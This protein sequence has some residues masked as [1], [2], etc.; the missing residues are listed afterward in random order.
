MLVATGLLTARADIQE[1]ILAHSQGE[2]AQRRNQRR[3]L[4]PAD[5]SPQEVQVHQGDSI[6][7]VLTAHGRPGRTI[8]F[9]IRSQPEHGTIEGPPRQL[10]RNTVSVTYVH[11]AADGPGNDRFTYAVQA[12]GT[13][14]SAPV[15]VTITVLDEP[16]NLV[17]TPAELDFGVVKTGENTRATLTLENRGG[18]TAIGRIEPPPPWAVD[19]SAEYHLGHG[20]TQSFQVVFQPPYGQSYVESAHV[21]AENGQDVRLIGSGIGPVDPSADGSIRRALPSDGIVRA[22]GQSP[23]AASMG[24]PPPVAVSPPPVPEPAAPVSAQAAAAT[25]PLPEIAATVTA[26]PLNVSP[27]LGS[28]DVNQA[29]VKAVEVAAVSTSTLD[30]AWKTP[31]PAP[32]SYRIELRYL[33][34]DIGDKLRVDWRPYARVDIRPTQ[35]QV[36][37]RI[38][39][40][41]PGTHQTLR[42]VA[43]DAAGRLAPPSPVV[44]VVMRQASTWWHITPLK[45]LVF[46]LMI[47]GGLMIYRRW[48]LRQVMRSIDESRAARNADLMFRS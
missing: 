12:P 41:D 1:P 44:V 14:L 37:A 33:S 7:I 43:V 25:P 5:G 11:R 27:P 40:L 47:C 45:V 20:E 19:G 30:L 21:H 29:S 46:L 26:P 6:D 38:S 31:A 10:T 13:A 4:V 35:S 32:K 18:G 24:L 16:P 23:P 39:G 42:V 36:T 8:D 9:V 17:A 34:L 15:P 48:E 2:R 28:V 3:E 22:S